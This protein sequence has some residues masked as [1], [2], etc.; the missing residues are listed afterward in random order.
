MRPAPLFRLPTWGHSVV[1]LQCLTSNHICLYIRDRLL[2]SLSKLCCVQSEWSEVST[3]FRLHDTFRA[4]SRPG[5]SRLSF[6]QKLK[7]RQKWVETDILDNSIISAIVFM[8]AP[9]RRSG[10]ASVGDVARGVAELAFFDT[11]SSSLTDLG[12]KTSTLEKC[13]ENFSCR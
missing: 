5:C 12:L 8:G 9:N 6:S 1:V 13:Q 10:N 11:N 7:L 2:G 4:I 3:R